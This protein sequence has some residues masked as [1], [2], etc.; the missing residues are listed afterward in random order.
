M[1]VHP[2]RLRIMTP[3]SVRK[4]RSLVRVTISSP[5][6]NRSPPAVRVRQPRERREFRGG[7]HAGL[8]DYHR[9]PGRKPVE[10]VEGSG[11]PVMLVEK[12]VDGV[13]ANARLLCEDG[14]G[15]RRGG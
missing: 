12:L 8:I 5:T 10:R 4:R 2:A 7:A 3:W 14:G 6:C 13:G 1:T 9:C 11:G 15:G